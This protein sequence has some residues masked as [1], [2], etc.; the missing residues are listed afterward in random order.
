MLSR[1]PSIDNHLETD[2]IRLISAHGEAVASSRRTLC[3]RMAR[4]VF[5]ML[6]CSAMAAAARPRSSKRCCS[7]PRPSPPWARRGW[8]DRE[9]LRPRRAEAPP[10]D[11]PCAGHEAYKMAA[12]KAGTVILEPIY[13]LAISVPAAYSGDIIARRGRVLG[14]LPSD[15][16]ALITAQVPYAEI[17]RYATDLRSMTQGR[18]HFHMAFDHYEDMPAQLAAQLAERQRSEY[19]SH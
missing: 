5:T 18:G 13:Q 8:H 19:A 12:Q 6:G 9:R 16:H 15:G 7:P 3:E 11:Q 4:N 1:A 14:M 2:T 10:V 17:L